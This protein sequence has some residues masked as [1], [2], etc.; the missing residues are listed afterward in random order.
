VY[1]RPSLEK[2]CEAVVQAMVVDAGQRGRGV[3]K[4]LMAHAEAW[5]RHRGLSSV[6]LSTRHAASF[7]ER[8][9]YHSVTATELMRKVLREHG[10]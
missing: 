6:A 7:Y 10:R 3:G 9:G 1:E 8:L 2:P 5:A 4:V